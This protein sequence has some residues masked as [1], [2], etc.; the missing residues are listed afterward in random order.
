[1]LPFTH[2]MRHTYMHTCINA[3]MHMCVCVY[4]HTQTN[5]H[6]QIHTHTSTY[7]RAGD[8]RKFTDSGT[9]GN[10]QGPHTRATRTH[11]HTHTH[12]HE[13]ATHANSQAVEPLATYKGHTSVV[14]D[15]AWQEFWKVSVL[16][17]LLSW[18][19]NGTHLSGEG[20]GLKYILKSLKSLRLRRYTTWGK[21]WNLWSHTS[22]TLP[23]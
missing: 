17:C 15:V 6:T 8:V 7:I 23:W 21:K 5:T 4:T 19:I 12:T 16:V 14:E 3:Y 1:M 18:Y 22:D 2:G 20:R 9:S 11:T 13:Q 10:I